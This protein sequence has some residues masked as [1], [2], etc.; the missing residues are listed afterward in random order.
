[1]SGLNVPQRTLEKAADW[2]T[3]CEQ[4]D[5]SSTNPRCYYGYVGPAR[6]N[7]MTAVGVLCRMYLG[8]PRRNRNLRRAARPSRWSSCRRCSRTP[9]TSITPPR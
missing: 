7:T 2:L 3:S 9:T 8:T 5:T 1:M 4:A 6:S